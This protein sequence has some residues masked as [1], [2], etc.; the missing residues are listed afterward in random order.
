MSYTDTQTGYVFDKGYYDF[1][2]KSNADKHNSIPGPQGTWRDSAGFDE[3]RFDR[4]VAAWNA[5]R[6]EQ[7]EKIE[8]DKEYSEHSPDYNNDPPTE[9]TYEPHDDGVPGPPAVPGPGADG[10]KDTRVNTVALQT[11]ADNMTTLR[12]HLD[13]P[14]ADL[15]TVQISG[16]TFAVANTLSAKIEG[17]EL[18]TGLAKS[19]HEFIGN[20][21]DTLLLVNQAITKMKTEYGNA[22]ELN[23]MTGEQLTK[24]FSA[25]NGEI[26]GLGADPGV[27]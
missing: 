7:I 14:L 2:D 19:T 17:G 3:A 20:V 5:Y 22:E 15:G 9:I 16:G 11:F 24:G 12:G 21:Q 25:V 27:V 18:A 4:E 26:T 23:A 10:G 13:K 1:V 6:E 8:N